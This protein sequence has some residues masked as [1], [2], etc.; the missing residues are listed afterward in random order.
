[1]GDIVARGAYGNCRNARWTWY[2]GSSLMGQ[3]WGSWKMY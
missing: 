3:S 2:T 1:M